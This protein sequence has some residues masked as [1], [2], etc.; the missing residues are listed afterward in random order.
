MGIKTDMQ[1]YYNFDL[2][3]GE[4]C[5]SLN[6]CKQLQS[7]SD[8]SFSVITVWLGECSLA[9]TSFCIP[10]GFPLPPMV[11]LC[12]WREEPTLHTWAPYTVCSLCDQEPYMCRTGSSFRPPPPLKYS[13]GKQ[14]L[15]S[16][17]QRR[18][19]QLKLCYCGPVGYVCTMYPWKILVFLVTY[20][21]K[22]RNIFKHVSNGSYSISEQY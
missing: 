8:I 16:V 7:Y 11:F 3:S 17:K 13:R 9:H 2:S 12:V 21:G 1:Y 4:P 14:Y 19:R 6:I 18:S 22:H 5:N 15:H 10:I 20:I